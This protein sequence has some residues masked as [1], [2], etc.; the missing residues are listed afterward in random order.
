[1]YTA[2]QAQNIAAERQNHNYYRIYKRRTR[3]IMRELTHRANLGDMSLRFYTKK[4]NR[5]EIDVLRQIANELNLIG[6]VCNVCNE[7]LDT[8]HKIWFIDIQ[9]GGEK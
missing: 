9:W 6:Y 8:G 5:T 2:I 1:M 7:K 4:G 3:A